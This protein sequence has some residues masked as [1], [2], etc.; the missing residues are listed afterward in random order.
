MVAR[1]S[2]IKKARG[3]AEAEVRATPRGAHDVLTALAS[4]PWLPAERAERA[5]SAGRRCL[6]SPC[7]AHHL[8]AVLPL[9]LRKVQARRHAR[10]RNRQRVG[11]PAG[12]DESSQ[13]AGGDRSARNIRLQHEC[14]HT[15]VGAAQC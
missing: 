10:T 8:R 15:R 6:A 7:E 2:S 9:L 3:R 1:P 5:P 12:D 4:L 14:E 11:V 13:A